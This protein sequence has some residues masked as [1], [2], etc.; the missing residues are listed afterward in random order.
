MVAKEL[1]IRAKVFWLGGWLGWVVGLGFFVCW[2][3]FWGGEM[4]LKRTN[5]RRRE[6]RSFESANSKLARG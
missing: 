4:G 3:V 2:L 5:E 6:D 1:L